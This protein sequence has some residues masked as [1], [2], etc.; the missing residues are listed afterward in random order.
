MLTVDEGTYTISAKNNRKII[1]LTRNNLR[2][3]GTTIKEIRYELDIQVYPKPNVGNNIPTRGKYFVVAGNTIPL[4]LSTEG[5]YDEGWTFTWT[6]NDKVIMEGVPRLD[7][8]ADNIN[9]YPDTI[10]HTL[11][12]SNIL[13]EKIGC[14]GE[15]D[16]VV[17]D[18]SVPAKSVMNL[19]YAQNARQNDVRKFSIS[20]PM[21]GNPDGWYYKWKKDDK[22]ITTE[23]VKWDNKN[24]GH[25]REF[26]MELDDMPKDVKHSENHHY[27]FVYT[28]L[29]DEGYA[30]IVPEKIEFPVTVYQRPR[31]PAKIVQKG[32]GK[33]DLFIL[34]YD[35]F[36]QEELEAADILFDFYM[37]NGEHLYTGKERVIFFQAS[38]NRLRARSLWKYDSGYDC[39]SDP[40]GVGFMDDTKAP[41]Y[42]ETVNVDINTNGLPMS[43]TV[44]S[45]TGEMVKRIDDV[46]QKDYNETEMLQNLPKGL[47]ILHR[48]SGNQRVVK[49]VIV[50]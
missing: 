23:W 9:E 22:D 35:D 13:D 40:V 27:D 33:S 38:Q 3:D 45:M 41:D 21:G 49:K 34:M 19:D 17:V 50:E 26:V 16:F 36:E 31:K 48:I 18:Y 37:E 1:C 15:F 42:I 11:A 5:G 29:D 24:K 12:Y 2:E 7:Y 10:V 44:Y 4:I 28:N 32:T 30:L 43:A 20:A 46:M 14:K 39:Y 47:Y 8:L 6:I 25:I